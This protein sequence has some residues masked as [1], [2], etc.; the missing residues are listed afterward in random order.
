MR[1]QSN[2]CSYSNLESIAICFCFFFH[3][4]M[5]LFL[6]MSSCSPSGSFLFS[7]YICPSILFS[8]SLSLL[9]LYTGL[10]KKPDRQNQYKM[11]QWQVSALWVCCQTLYKESDSVEW[12]AE[13]WNEQGESNYYGPEH[14]SQWII[15]IIKSQK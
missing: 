11:C 3:Y 7:L 15:P 4:E 10:S 5:Y 2:Q 13:S 12:K 8:V 14:R 6:L 9:K 1:I